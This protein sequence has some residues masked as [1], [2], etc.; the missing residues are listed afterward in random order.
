MA[1]THS[2]DL[3]AILLGGQSFC[4]NEVAPGRFAGWIQA[5]PVHLQV[6]DGSVHWDNPSLSPDHIR[7][8]LTLDLDFASI[9]KAFPSHDPHLAEARRTHPGLRVVREDPWECLANFIC[10]SLKQISQIRQINARLR[11]SLG[12]PARLFPSPQILAKAG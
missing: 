11:T 2:L 5:Q 7:H 10:S 12:G 9:I 3:S 4:W 8:Y 1:L 6:L